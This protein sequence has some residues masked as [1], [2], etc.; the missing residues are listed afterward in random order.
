MVIIYHIIKKYYCNT[1]TI[2]EHLVAVINKQYP[3]KILHIFDAYYQELAEDVIQKDR[4]LKS[5]EEDE[6][7][8]Q[9]KE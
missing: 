9:L 3:N 4:L 8:K 6:L 2:A 1:S 5:K 7:E